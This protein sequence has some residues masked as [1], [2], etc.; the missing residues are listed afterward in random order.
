MRVNERIRARTVRVIDSDGKQLGILP[1][2]EALKIAEDREL[3][4]VEVAP[5][6]SPPVCKIMDFG[7][8]KYELKKRQKEAKKK[9][10][11][12]DVKTMELRP[13]IGEADLGFKLKKAKKWLEDGDKV[14]ILMIFRGRELVHKN[15]GFDVVNRVIDELSELGIV[16][17][18]PVFQGRK[19][20]A[21]MSP[22]R[23]K[24][25]GKKNGEVKTAKNSKEKV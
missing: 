5:N 21:L 3:D 22:N 9:Q 6:A 20:E 1:I 7:K 23:K 25:G 14:K 11:S 15:K 10:V 4:L 13:F 16:E 17:R 2:A 18:K 8:Y 19:I 12:F 24:E